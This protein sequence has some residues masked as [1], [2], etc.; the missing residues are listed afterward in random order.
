MLMLL[1]K[2]AFES[3]F[4]LRYSINASLD[5]WLIANLL[6]DRILVLRP[7]RINVKNGK[8][9]LESASILVIIGYCEITI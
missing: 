2:K 8:K 6:R 9:S 7:A 3:P 4:Y 5:P 1:Q